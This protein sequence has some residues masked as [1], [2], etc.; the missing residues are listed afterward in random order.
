MGRSGRFRG[1]RVPSSC[2]VS[3]TRQGGSH[4]YEYRTVYVAP[5]NRFEHRQ[6][7]WRIN[8]CRCQQQRNA[9]TTEDCEAWWAEEAGLRD[10][11]AGR[12]RTMFMKAGHG[13]QVQRYLRGLHDGQAL[14]CLAEPA[15]QRSMQTPG[16]LAF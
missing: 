13:P 16:T 6:I 2:V 1:E 5:C 12:D 14:L 15:R 7:Q 10:A 9:G 8:W 4:G 11:L 3:V